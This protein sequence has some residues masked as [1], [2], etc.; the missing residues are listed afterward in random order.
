[1]NV[2]VL[3]ILGQ[4]SIEYM[5]TEDIVKMLESNI[6][7]LLPEMVIPIPSATENNSME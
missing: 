1:M 3:C 4:G 6:K 7:H 5:N 2:N